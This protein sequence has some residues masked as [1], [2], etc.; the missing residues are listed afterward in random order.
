M[1]PLM[2]AQVVP[3]SR[4]RKEW[5]NTVYWKAD[6][7]E[8]LAMQIGVDAQGLSSTVQKVNGYAQTGVDLDFDR[9]GNVF[10]RYYGDSNIKPNPCL[11]PLRKGPYYAMRLDA[12]DIGTKGGL[13]TNQHA[14]VVR[15]DG[16]PIAGLY[17]IGNCSASVMGISYPGAGGTLGPA[18]TFGYIAANH[19]ARNVSVMASAK[20]GALS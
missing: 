1:G 19:I 15:E 9:G 2:P 3:D 20:V 5:L 11:A 6:S 14:Q 10:D 17:A 18:M 8:A 16:Q 12:G 7:L 13:L 4:L